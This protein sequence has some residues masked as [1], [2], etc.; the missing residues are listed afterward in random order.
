MT[1]ERIDSPH[2]HARIGALT[3]MLGTTHLHGADSIGLIAHGAVEGLAQF[4]V[5]KI[6]PEEAYN[7]LQQA[8]DTV[9]KRIVTKEMQR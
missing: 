7:L 5:L 8:A 9:A 6:G 2:Y 3:M 1:T 4:M